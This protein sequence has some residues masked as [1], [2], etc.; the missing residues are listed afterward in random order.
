L[1][2]RLKQVVA[3][4]NKKYD[5]LFK[6]RGLGLIDLHSVV[7]SLRLS[8]DWILQK[9]NLIMPR[10]YTIA[11]S[12]LAHPDAITIAISLSRYEVTLT[13]GKVWR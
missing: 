5:E 13:E 9:C 12:S 1:F 7:P 2:D 10:Y 6:E 4:G 3:S 8:V 11:S